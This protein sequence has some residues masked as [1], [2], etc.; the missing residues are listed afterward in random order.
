MIRMAKKEAK[1]EEFDLQSSLDEIEDW[2]WKVEAFRKYITGLGIE[3]KSSK[4]LEKQ[5]ADFYG[6]K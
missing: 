6:G 4:E 3:I 5:Y 2:D 1:K